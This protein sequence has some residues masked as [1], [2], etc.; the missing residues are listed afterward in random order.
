MNYNI[1][2]ND[3]L[4]ELNLRQN[5]IEIVI[6]ADPSNSNKSLHKFYDNLFNMPIA[7]TIQSDGK[8]EASITLSFLFVYSQTPYSTS[9]VNGNQGTP[10]DRYDYQHNE[11]FNDLY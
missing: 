6:H 3:L 9:S 8:T 7:N 5:R 10:G 2:Y 11:S 1:S 4:Q